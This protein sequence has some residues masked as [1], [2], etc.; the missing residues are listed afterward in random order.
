MNK[1]NYYKLAPTHLYNMSG[2]SKLFETQEEVDQAWEDGWFGPPFLAKTTALM[3]ATAFESK[4]AMKSAVE[5]DPRYDGLTLNLR[6]NKG[7]LIANILEFE[8]EHEIEPVIV[9]G[10]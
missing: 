9:G 3:S 7:E 10:E 8:E 2:K 4:R 1:I 5:A 6:K